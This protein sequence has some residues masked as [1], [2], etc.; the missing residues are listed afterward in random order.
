MHAAERLRNDDPGSL[1][2][3]L[4]NQRF[5]RFEAFAAGLGRRLRIIDL[6]GTPDYWTA[7]GWADRDDVHITLVNLNRFERTHE[8]IVP[9]QGD[10]T[11]VDFEAQAFDLVFS[12]SVIEHLYTFERQRR[13]ALEVRRLAPAYWVQT[14]N[15]WFPIEPHYLLPGLQWLPIGARAQVLGRLQPWRTAPDEDA[16]EVRLLRRRELELLF[17]GTRL[18]PE[19]VAGLVKSWT[20]VRGPSG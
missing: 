1:S 14:P 11:A 6:G 5:A 16:R 4:R 15:Y 20:V 19:R 13:M 18:V 17:P 8:N 9:V 7:R 12:N 10:A 2:H 3:R